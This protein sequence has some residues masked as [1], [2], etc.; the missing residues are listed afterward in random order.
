M[1]YSKCTDQE[2][3]VLYIS[4]KDLAFEQLI[5]RHKN[6][7]YTKIYLMVKDREITEDIFQDCFIKVINT[8]RKG[9]YND[10]G[11]FLPWV[12]RI[13]HNLVIDYFRKG[14]KMPTVRSDENYDVFSTIKHD[15]L[16]IE[17]QIVKDQIMGDVKKLI[18]ELPQDQK[19]VVLMR[20]YY[21]M[22]FKEISVTLDISINTALGR[23]RYALIN[24]RKIVDEKN[25]NL[26]VN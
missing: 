2:L 5:A 19:E 10:E 13:A 9:K 1:D 8:L 11:K 24:L 15:D 6:R 3:V 25:I 4:G 18:K 22:S 16:H 21:K 12:L 17:D 20:I 7:V 14:K 23:M 26:L